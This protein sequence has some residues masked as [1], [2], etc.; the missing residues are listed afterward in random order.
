MSLEQDLRNLSRVPLF[1]LL[2]PDARR[3]LA[4][5]GE[6]K[7]LRA[8]DVLFRKGEQ[9]DGGYVVLS[10]SIALNAHARSDESEKIVEPYSLIGEIAVISQTERAV[11]AVAREPTAVL[12]ISRS[13]F[14]RVLKEHP[15]SA[16]RLRETIASRLKNFTNELDLARS[17]SFQD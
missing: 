12:K 15:E 13:L 4:F 11:T 16:V 9:S 5:S 17:S 10:G 1:A 3:L 14:H 7:L 6:T 2:E 8:G